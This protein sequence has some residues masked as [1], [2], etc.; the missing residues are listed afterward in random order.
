MKNYEAWKDPTLCKAIKV[1]LSL[2][3][4]DRGDAP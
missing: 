2:D 4:W 3:G 1:V